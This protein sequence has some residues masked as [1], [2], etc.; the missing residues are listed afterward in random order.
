[1]DS[2]T[3]TRHNSFQNNRELTH[4]FAPEPLILKLEQEALK[5]NNICM[6]WSSPKSDT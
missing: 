6:S 1:M 2:L 3:L 5:F 4:S